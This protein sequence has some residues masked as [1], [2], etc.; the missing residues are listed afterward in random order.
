MKTPWQK[1]DGVFIVK[2]R[3]SEKRKE[4]LAY[5]SINIHVEEKPTNLK[6]LSVLFAVS[7][8]FKDV[9]TLGE[10]ERERKREREATANNY[11]TSIDYNSPQNKGF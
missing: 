6:L 9:E 8:H 1:P 5:N 2:Y 4:G 11:F 7:Y 3:E 10:R